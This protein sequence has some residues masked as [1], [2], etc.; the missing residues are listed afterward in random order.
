MIETVPI[1]RR[2]SPLGPILLFLLGVTS[3]PLEAESCREILAQVQERWWQWREP[4]WSRGVEAR[5]FREAHERS[6]KDLTRPL[7]TPTDLTGLLAQVIE[8]EFGENL[9]SGL[10]DESASPSERVRASRLLRGLS[11]ERGLTHRQIERVIERLDRLKGGGSF[12]A[13]A[14]CEESGSHASAIGSPSVGRE[15]LE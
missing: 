8:E 13:H 1:F 12:P 4:S 9:L 7:I 15:T 11:L 3:F 5:E 10:E 2:L 6:K 14:A